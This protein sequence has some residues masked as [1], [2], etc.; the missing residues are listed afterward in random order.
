M[1]IRRDCDD[2]I[3]EDLAVTVHSIRIYNGNR[4]QDLSI[5]KELC[6]D[7]LEEYEALMRVIEAEE[8]LSSMSE[9]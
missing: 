3:L 9:A 2:E 7:C 4:I 5:R 1:Q 8:G 6:R